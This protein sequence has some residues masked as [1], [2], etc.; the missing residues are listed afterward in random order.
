M[1]V[2]VDVG[3]LRAMSAYLCVLVGVSPWVRGGWDLDA[4][5]KF[6]VVAVV[7]AVASGF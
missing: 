2:H 6:F 3:R 1:C 5:G 7:V 4:L